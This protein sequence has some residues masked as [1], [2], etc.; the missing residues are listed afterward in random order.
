MNLMLR[1]DHV[2]QNEKKELCAVH[3]FENQ[4]SLQIMSHFRKHERDVL[5]KMCRCIEREP[6]LN[7]GKSVFLFVMYRYDDVQMYSCGRCNDV[8][9][10]K[11]ANLDGRVRQYDNL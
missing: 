6:T 3:R 1:C 7:N 9:L 8:P 11:R 2:A 10:V 5:Y 4:L